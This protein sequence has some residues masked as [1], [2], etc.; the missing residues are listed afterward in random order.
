MA[1]LWQAPNATVP[2][3]G[4]GA[5]SPLNRPAGPPALAGNGAICGRLQTFGG[6]RGHTLVVQRGGGAVGGLGPDAGGQA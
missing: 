6:G 5:G 2:S 1:R 3:K 4:E